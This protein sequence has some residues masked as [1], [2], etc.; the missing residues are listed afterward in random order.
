[1]PQLLDLNLPHLESAAVVID[2]HANEPAWDQALIV[3]EFV[4]YRPVPDA[5]PVAKA[6]VRVLSDAMGL[7]VHYTVVDPEPESV[8]ARYATRDNIWGGETAG[9]YLDPAGD[10]QRAYLFLCNPYGI[11]SDATRVAGSG[12]SFSWDGQWM[13]AGRVTDTG[14]EIEIGIPWSSVRHP[15]SIDQIGLS[16]L[17]SNY[18][19]SQ[20]SGWPRRDPDVNG[21]LIQQ[22]ILTDPAWLNQGIKSKSSRS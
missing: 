22:A 9:L 2:S 5:E 12:D 15:P 18:R 19:E 4:S 3:D 6:T 14:Y 8:N 1:M 20:R 17:Y 7:Y 16:L 13:S 11:Q 10:G 21:I